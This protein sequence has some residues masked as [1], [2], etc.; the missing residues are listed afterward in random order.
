V[1]RWM[2]V[3]ELVDEGEFVALAGRSL[4]RLVEQSHL[5]IG[6]F[7]D[8]RSGKKSQRKLKTAI[9]IFTFSPNPTSS[10]D[11]FEVPTD[12]GNRK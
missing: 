2:L 12:R 5:W 11:S 3:P 1:F 7:L 8:A 6:G 4:A 10:S 9:L